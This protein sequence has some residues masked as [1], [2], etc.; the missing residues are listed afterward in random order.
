MKINNWLAKNLKRKT[1]P[2]E[3]IISLVFNISEKKAKRLR[4]K[5]INKIALLTKY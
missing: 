5:F 4:A 2:S 3:K 1:P